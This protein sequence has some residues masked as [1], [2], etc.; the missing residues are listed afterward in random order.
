LSDEA[1]DEV[2]NKLLLAPEQ[3]GCAGD[4]DPHTV[5]RV[6]S[7]DGRITDAPTRQLMERGLVL[8]RR[9][10]DHVQVRHQGLRMGDRL[11]WT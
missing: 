3:M 4:V 1:L 11:A 7:D 6:R 2:R 8:F 10:I 5:G 9:R